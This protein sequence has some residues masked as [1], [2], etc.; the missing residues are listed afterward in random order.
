MGVHVRTTGTTGTA[1]ATRRP[2]PGL[3]RHGSALSVLEGASAV[4][5]RGW[6][7]HA[8][9][10]VRTADGRLTA[11]GRGDLVRS[12]LVAAVVEAAHWRDDDPSAAG[13]ALD[14]LWLALH[15]RPGAQVGDGAVGPVPAPAVRELRAR[16]LARWN[17]APQR[18]Q[19]EVLALVERAA[20]RVR[21]ELDPAV[22]DPAVC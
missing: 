2:R 5:H 8:E 4:L 6:L 1:T 18:T 16:D 3:A 13:P 9:R 17:D 20:E 12:C 14:A 7:Q 11:R 15:E 22:E 10:E 19:A 21:A